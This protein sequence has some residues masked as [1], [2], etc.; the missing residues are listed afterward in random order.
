MAQA[1][2]CG[3]RD[4]WIVGIKL[5]RSQPSRSPDAN[6]PQKRQETYL[7]ECLHE[8]TAIGFGEV[9]LIA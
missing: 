1:E 2:L 5:S 3:Y 8:P 9:M 4:K 6:I 7:V